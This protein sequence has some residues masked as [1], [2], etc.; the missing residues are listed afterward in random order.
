VRVDSAN[1]ETDRVSDFVPGV[2]LNREF[3]GSVVAPLLGARRHSAG[4]LGWGSDVLGFD[5]ER[6]TD[7]AW[8][9][10]L[11]VFVS[12]ADVASVRADIDL[13][14]PETFQGWPVRFGWDAIPVSHHVE[15]TTLTSWL[16]R[17]FG[18]DPRD[19][20]GA[21]DWLVVPQQQLLG[22]VRGGVFHDGLGELEPLRR[23]LAWFP[24]PVWLW[25]VACQWR[26][27]EQEEA[28]VGRS[29]EVGDTL[30]SRIIC[31]R[32]V[33]EVM[34]LHFLLTRTYAPYTKWFGTAYCELPAAAEM[35]PKLHAAVDA[36]TENAR[37][38]ALCSVYEAVADLHNQTGLTKPVVT[39]TRPFYGR[40]YR[41]LAA[42]R[43]VQAC[44]DRLED[45]W[46]ESLPLIG[47]ID[48]CID[49][50]DVLSWRAV[51]AEIAPRLRSLYAGESNPRSATR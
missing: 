4:L 40:P 16:Q 10:R 27:I 14:L 35:L 51:A 2:A 46:L 36:T 43:F 25:L 18:H 28:F 23:M 26:R 8:G 22:V 9:P 30:G 20:M 15:V 11:T 7:H 39:A 1:W 32:L 17:W 3:Y 37:E 41:V 50:T 49:S 38:S 42:N 34:R 47:S 19:H 45:S 31:T 48:Q 5:T 24:E 6:S 13:R 29:A 44:L 21:T 12:A 33:R